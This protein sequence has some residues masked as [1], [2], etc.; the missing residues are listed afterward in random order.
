MRESV[1]RKS[2]GSRAR[3]TRLT[4]FAKARAMKKP[5]Q[6]R[7]AIVYD[8]DGTLA[9]GNLQERSFI[10]AIGATREEFWKE[11]RLRAK[12]E[13]SDEILVYMR[14]MLEK[15]HAVGEDVTLDALRAHGRNPEFFAGVPEWFDRMNAFAAGFGLTLEHYVV[16]SGNHELIEGCS[17][18]RE[19]RRVFASR[20]MYDSEGRAVWPGVAINY[21]TKTQFLF[22]IN[23]G[24]DNS[25]D[26]EA[27]NTWIPEEKRPLPFR[28]MIFVGDG[29]TDIPS[30]KM[31]M[32]QGGC[33]IG[34]LDPERWADA[35]ENRNIHKLIAEDRVS[36]VAPADYSEGGQLDVI[37]RGALGKIALR[38]EF[39]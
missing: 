33:A 19:F 23:K 31:V 25:W 39:A 6:T 32:T 22:R 20:F 1:V 37:V 30:M 3:M 21:T 11:V 36:F 24:V 9:R 14:L 4:C 12:R 18:T 7:A 27:V 15:A 16:S 2:G 8:F 13:D 28:R 5:T 26:N 10:P 35:Q 34:V 29:L 17:I 38:E